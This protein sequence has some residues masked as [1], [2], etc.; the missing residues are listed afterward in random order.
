MRR[1]RLR[2]GLFWTGVILVLDLAVTVARLG[3][4]ARDLMTRKARPAGLP[5]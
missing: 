3:V 1:R 5:T 4:A 2:R